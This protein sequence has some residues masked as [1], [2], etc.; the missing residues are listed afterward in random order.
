MGH[1]PITRIGIQPFDAST[2]GGGT[3]GEPVKDRRLRHDGGDLNA[4]PRELTREVDTL[5]LHAAERTA[6]PKPPPFAGRNRLST[7]GL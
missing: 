1:L 6:G 3:L 7:A 5:A 4:A 2:G